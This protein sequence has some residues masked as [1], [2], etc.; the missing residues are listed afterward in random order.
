MVEVSVTFTWDKPMAEDMAES[1][2]KQ[3]YV[4]ALGGPAYGEPGGEFVPGKY[5]AHGYTITSRGCPNKCPHCLVPKR[6]GSIRTL[7]IR[8]GWDVLD[9]NLLACPE[10]HI[11]AVLAM[12]RRQPQRPRFTGGL[13]ASRLT[14]ELIGEIFSSHPAVVYL[15]YDRPEMWPIVRRA[16]YLIRKFKG[17]RRGTIRSHVGC[18][19]MCGYEG[20]TI[21]EAARRALQ[22]MKWGPRIYPMYYRS[23]GFTK[24]PKEWREFCGR[25]MSMG[26]RA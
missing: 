9:N 15:A 20:D 22:I 16:F 13:E 21:S 4:V 7:P 2:Q 23:E 24:I 18:Y 1:W 3:G 5:L 19:M 11:S 12:L 14:P 26:G 25:L 8:D 6:E 17:W 10:S